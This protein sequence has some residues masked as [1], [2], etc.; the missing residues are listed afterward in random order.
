MDDGQRRRPSGVDH[1]EL[2]HH[3]LV[4]LW[5]LLMIRCGASGRGGWGGMVI[6]VEVGN[7]GM[8]PR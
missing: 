5:V 6:G 1:D 2:L 7:G 8:K 3:C 4:I